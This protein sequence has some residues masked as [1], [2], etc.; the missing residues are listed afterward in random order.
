MLVNTGKTNVARDVSPLFD[1]ADADTILR[2]I[3]NLDFCVYRIILSQVSP[4]FRDMFTFPHPPSPGPGDKPDVDYKDGLPLV[5]LPESNTTLSMLLY[6]IYP[7]PSSTMYKND[8]IVVGSGGGALDTLTDAWLTADKYE[9]S[10]YAT[11]SRRTTVRCC[12][13][14]LLIDTSSSI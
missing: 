6:A 9:I 5:Q 1:D 14:V 8:G 13:L 10:S 4:V 3:D 7:V 12:L 11:H 2:P